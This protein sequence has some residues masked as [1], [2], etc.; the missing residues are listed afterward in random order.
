[1]FFLDFS[2]CICCCRCYLIFCLLSQVPYPVRLLVLSQKKEKFKKEKFVDNIR[3]KK[4]F[5][6][7]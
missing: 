1:M 2:I 3:T 7:K 6:E 5:R 4:K